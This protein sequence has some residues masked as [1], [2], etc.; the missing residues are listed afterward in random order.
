MKLM[1]EKVLIYGVIIDCGDG[2]VHPNWFLSYESA[3]CYED[4]VE[5]GWG[6][7]FHI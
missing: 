5:Q 3:E 4:N 2:S 7:I 6:R 1:L